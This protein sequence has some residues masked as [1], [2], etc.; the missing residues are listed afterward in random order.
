MHKS[1]GRWLVF[2]GVGVLGFAVQLATLAALL[3]WTPVHYLLATGVAVETAVLHNFVWHQQ[4]TWRDRPVD[5]KCAS[6]A[7]LGRFHLTNGAISL[8]GNL[9]IM[10]LLTGTLHVDPV[11]ANAVAVI[12]CSVVNFLASDVIVFRTAAA[13][14]ALVVAPVPLA[15]HVPADGM[16]VS[17][18]GPATLA[19]WDEYDRR[20]NERYERLTGSSGS[21]FVHDA[22]GTPGRWRAEALSGQVPMLEIARPG[23][24]LPEIDVPG[25]RIH[26]WAGAVFIPGATL[27]RV[28]SRIRDGAGHEA[29]AYDDVLASRLLERHGDRVVVYM[30]LRRE[31]I[32]TVT[33]NTTH[34]IEYRRLG[35]AHAASRSVATRIAELAGAGTATEREKPEGKDH[36]F[37]WKLNA[38]WRYE[39]TA[40]G[41]LIECESVSLSRSVPLLVRP[42]VNGTVERIA[43]ESLQ[44]TLLN[45]RRV[46]KSGQGRT[47]RLPAASRE[48]RS[49]LNRSSNALRE[50]VGAVDLVSRSTVVRGS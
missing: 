10:R 24:G 2:N 4:W 21:F 9:A 35:P 48:L 11:A 15:A 49:Y 12:V 13:A 47:L 27:D 42:L 41:V 28:L 45:L 33:Y 17:A 32:I 30:K 14:L 36:G 19:A 7:R 40:G 5:A 20:V 29:G 26:H 37:L 1:A 6:L 18:P 8:A 34:A 31:S 43:R 44:R 16:F 46:L 3:R 50:V 39:E 23:P 25:G 38:Y 22:F